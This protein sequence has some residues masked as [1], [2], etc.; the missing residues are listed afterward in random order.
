MEIVE[1]LKLMEL[2]DSL[3][4]NDVLKTDYSNNLILIKI[5]AGCL[6]LIEGQGISLLKDNTLTI[7]CRKRDYRVLS[8]WQPISFINRGSTSRAESFKGSRICEIVGKRGRVVR[9]EEGGRVKWARERVL[10][11]A[12]RTG[13]GR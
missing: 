4:K 10:E 9:R 2:Q 5:F 13:R 8:H 1:C 7:F 11:S 3:V 6:K 12:G